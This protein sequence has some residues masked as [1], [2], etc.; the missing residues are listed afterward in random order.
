MEGGIYGYDGRYM[1]ESMRD[2]NNRRTT[3]KKGVKD[4]GSVRRGRGGGTFLRNVF[5]TA[6][7]MLFQNVS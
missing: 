1:Y 6:S 2:G 5:L 4:N 3:R 7:V